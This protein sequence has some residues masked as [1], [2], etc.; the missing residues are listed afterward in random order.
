[1]VLGLA[2][3][4]GVAAA[5]AGSASDSSAASR[6]NEQARNR[7]SAMIGHLVPGRKVRCLQHP[8]R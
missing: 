1:M 4:W 8:D 6:I 7:I 5:I 3:G 2:I